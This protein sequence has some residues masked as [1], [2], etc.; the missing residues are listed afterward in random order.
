MLGDDKQLGIFVA[1]RDFDG[2]PGA[3]PYAGD[4]IKQMVG[5]DLFEP[6]EYRAAKASYTFQYFNLL[7]K[8][9]S[10]N[11]QL[12]IGADWQ[13]LNG[14]ERQAIK[15]AVF[16]KAQRPTKT[17]QATNFK[18]IRKILKLPE[19]ARFNLV[20]YGQSQTQKDIDKIEKKTKFVSL[21]PYHDLVKVLPKELWQNNQLLDYIGTAL[22]FYSSDRRRRRYFKEELNL[23]NNI[24]EE[25]LLLNFTKFGHLSIKSMKKIIPYL[26]MGQ[27][28]SDA[29]RNA[30]YDFREKKISDEMIRNE[31]ANPV[32][33]RAVTK[34]I[35][36][37]KQII[38]RYGQPDGINIEL[39]RDLGRSFKE[40][41]KMQ[42]RQDQN[43]VSNEKIA[44]ELTELGIPV[45]GQNIIRYKLYKE[46]KEIDP[47]TGEVI[48]FTQLFSYNYE[49]DHIIP[50]S[51]SWDD[52]Y[53][54]KVLTSVKCNREKGNRIPMVYLAQDE[55]R[56]NALINMADNI[57]C[58]YRK[59][60]KLLKKD[61]S[62][63]EKSNWKNRNLNDTRYISKILL[64]YF[65]HEITFN[66][67]VDKKQRVLPLNGEVTAKIRNRWGFLKVRADSDLHHAIDA[68]VIACIT[69]KFI[70]QVTKYSQHQEIKNNQALWHAQEIKDAKYAAEAQRVNADLFNKIFNGFPLPWPQ[71]RDELLA[72]ISDNPAE[73]MKNQSW[74]TYTP[75]EIA[76]LK[77]VF[78]VRLANHKITGPAHL[79]TI[80][81]AKLYEEKGIVLSRVSISKLKINK[82]GQIV[83]GDG[84]YDPKNSN[85][86]DKVV[87][88]AIRKVLELHGN[89]GERA[90]PQGYLEYMDHGTK[91]LVRKVRVAKKASM[92]VRLKK[93]AVADN[94]SMVRIDVFRT[95][96]KYVFVPIYVRNTVEKELPNKAVVQSKVYKD[97]YQI[98]DKDRFCFSLYPGDMVH[99]ESKKG[100]RPRY[101]NKPR[102]A[103]AVPIK[104]FYGYFDGAD[105]STASITISAHDNSF[106]AKSIGIASLLKFEKYQVD[107]FGRYH[108]VHQ[109]KR[110][111][112]IK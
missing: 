25:L 5:K 109:K 8:I 112:F 42:K 14:L 72:R 24:I 56:L 35:K 105:I 92:P 47:Y 102:S 36:I 103:N 32:V 80:R 90:F 26:E 63:D 110:L 46:Q 96:K 75:N 45:N 62:D 84:I 66:P 52:S 3:G 17:Y 85:N 37:V 18:E 15:D 40:R 73:N 60:Q 108:K 51:I 99:I 6:N 28:Y 79:E 91:K 19:D 4:Q 33:K 93:Q 65:K 30:G 76:Q 49:V 10:L 106:F 87:Y 78:V 34:A 104:D 70:Q 11:Y 50:Y 74:T 43:R 20:N 59:R 111:P 53:T 86:G 58:N 38:R 41:K 13:K 27:V 44:K 100:F 95:P 101:R 16:A 64:N 81:S 94:G 77:R 98:T 22:T 7:Q 67:K 57:I 68:T 82:K 31:I 9:T 83:T 89:S 107:Y 48:P 61:L 97:W 69:P 71:F 21:K 55:Q 1:Q 54:N 39:A 2:G 23:T 12:T 88:Q 29:T